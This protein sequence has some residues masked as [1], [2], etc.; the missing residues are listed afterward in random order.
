[1]AF[2]PTLIGFPHFFWTET[3]YI[4]LLVCFTALLV[5]EDN[6]PSARQCF[7][8]GLVAGLASLTR[9][10][11]VPQLAFVALWILITGQA[12]RRRR[13]LSV[14][15]LLL[16]TAVVI[17]PWSVRSTVRNDRFLLI[18]TNAGNVLYKNWN[19]RISCI[20]CTSSIN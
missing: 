3:V 6:P 12:T 9:S 13:T 11:L 8:A 18:D 5:A 1:M 14:I 10:I 20:N 16:G 19:C 2:Y 17:A 7:F 4:F 15:A